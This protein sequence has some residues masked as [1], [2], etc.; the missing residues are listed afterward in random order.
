MLNKLLIAAIILTIAL[1]NNG[2]TTAV[3]SVATGQ[4]T[5]IHKYSGPVRQC[6]PI[7]ISSSARSQ[8]SR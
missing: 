2:T 1:A 8:V 4:N 3:Y 7:Q 6:P 5:R